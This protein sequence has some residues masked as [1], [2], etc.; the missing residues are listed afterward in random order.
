M[1]Q[2]HV[3]SF[4][5]RLATDRDLLRSFAS[6]PDTT[7]AIYKTEGHELAA[8]E[9]QALLALD[10]EALGRFAETLDARL[11]RLGPTGAYPAIESR[12]S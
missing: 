9:T 7:L 11:R 12:R 3:E 5:G 2:R 10:V 4:I 1:S 8:V 6:W